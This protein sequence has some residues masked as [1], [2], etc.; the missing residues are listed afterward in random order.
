MDV[1]R[2]LVVNILDM[3]IDGRFGC[4]LVWQRSLELDRIPEKS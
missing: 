4:L 2:W 1:M 3:D